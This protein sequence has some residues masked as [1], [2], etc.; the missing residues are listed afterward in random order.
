MTI[1]VFW[2]CLIG[3]VFFAL[4]TLLG[5]HSFHRLHGLHH[6][7]RFHG[8]RFLHPTTVVGAITAFGGA[9]I[10]LSKY[11]PFEGA[12][13]VAAALA[14]ALVMSVVVHF[15][16][17]RPISNSES[18]M[19]YSIADYVGTKGLVTVQIPA[20]GH[21]QV[22]IRMGAANACQVASSFDE[23]AIPKGTSVVVVEVRNGILHVSP[24]DV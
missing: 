21:G 18:S 12:A 11:T 8:L 24:A 6:S 17:V 22:M 20:R 13:L 23:E 1:E 2:G 19:G 5:G 10:I 9:G 7:L 15:A 16:Y 3:G 14:G 4:I